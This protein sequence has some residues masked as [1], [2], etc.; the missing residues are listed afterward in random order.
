MR[1]LVKEGKLEDIKYD[2][3]IYNT[4]DLTTIKTRL[5]SLGFRKD[6]WLSGS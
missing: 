1:A 4:Y 3:F 5:R 6:S 2:N